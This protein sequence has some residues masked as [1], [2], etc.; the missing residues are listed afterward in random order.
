VPTHPVDPASLTA[1][2]IAG[3]VDEA[4]ARADEL[5]ARA[6]AADA[7]RTL[8]D[9][10]LPLDEATALLAETSGRTAFM[11]YVHPEPDVRDAGR[12]AEERIDTWRVKVFFRSDLNQAVQ[13]FAATEEAAGLAG[14]PRRLLDFVLRDLRRAGHDLPEEDRRRLEEISTRLVEIGVRFQQNIDEYDDHLSVAREDL[15]GLP[16]EY[17]DGLAP[18]EPEGTLRVTMAYPEVIPFLENARRRDLR[19]QLSFKFSTRAL[20]ANRPLLTEAVL[21]RQQVAVLFGQPSWADHQMDD[22]MAKNPETVQQFYDELL[23]PL[24]AKGHDELEVM[25][26]LL[27]EDTAD[28]DAAVQLWDWRY[29]DTQIRRRDY[30]VDN[31][32]VA[33]YFPL[34]QVLDGL[35]AI[36]G[37][38]F[39]LEYRPRA[40]V[41]TWHPD[42]LSYAIHDAASGDEVAL[43][44]M[45]LHPRDGK[46]THAASFD[47][48]PGR[49]LPD[50]SYQRPVAT[51]VANFTK[52]TADRPS[53]LQHEEVLT[54]FHEF[55]HTLHQ[56]LTRVELARFAGTNTEVD[57]VE[58]PSQIMEHWTW[59]A[60][61]LS[62]FARHHE[63]GEPIPRGLVSKLVEARDLDIGLITL[64]QIQFG[65][66]DMGLHGSAEPP[67]GDDDIDAV[68]R[69][70]EAVA[71][72]PHQEGTFFPSS[73]GHLLAGYDAGYYGYL[74]SEVF[75]DDMFSRFEDEGVTN[76][77]VG[78]AYRREILE[79]GGSVDAVDMLRNFLG[80][81]PNN[82]AFLRKLGIAAT[83]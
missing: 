61:V 46:F 11:G 36:T 34:Q 65:V 41:P 53:L 3:L 78:M 81:E 33:A 83:V 67:R 51:I 9:T 20:D 82:R 64:R 24:T 48:R 39:G 71:L 31:N 25:R 58:A 8:A 55:G 79:K 32:E 1:A 63:T 5:V 2:D 13:E 37:E 35:L 7:P 19:E 62:R 80:R 18:G 68:F 70:A 66:L 60:D 50:G 45:D 40:D 72:L 38:V 14:E 69:R 56:T 23:P 21:L 43:F 44:H 26:R 28:S 12:Q 54:L 74:W 10:L 59:N 77:E 16:P 52:P 22:R 57:F 17:V 42:V 15:E 27:A 30:G 47:T 49:R 6:A 75:G 29:Y 4:I 76:P 73:F